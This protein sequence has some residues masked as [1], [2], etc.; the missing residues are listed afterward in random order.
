MCSNPLED[1][2]QSKYFIRTVKFMQVTLIK[3]SDE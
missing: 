3:Q 1:G 2:Q